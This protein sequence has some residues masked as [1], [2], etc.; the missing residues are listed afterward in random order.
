M[1]EAKLGNE[2][3]FQHALISHSCHLLLWRETKKYMNKV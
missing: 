1:I 2:L 3:G